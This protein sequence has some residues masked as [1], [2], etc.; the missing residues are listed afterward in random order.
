MRI[1]PI[2]PIWILTPIFLL[3]CFFLLKKRQLKGNI[4][5]ILILVLLFLINLR[6]QIRS[7]SLSPTTNNL[8]VL[9]VIDTTISM[10]AED[11]YQNDKNETSRKKRNN[12]ESI[13]NAEFIFSVTKNFRRVKWC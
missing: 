3:L 7:D 6:F 8:D 13:Y 11:G 1:H 10:N 12:Y 5:T 2:I 9:F 4:K